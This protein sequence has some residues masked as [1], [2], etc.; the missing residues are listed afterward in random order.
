MNLSE[1]TITTT[2]TLHNPSS[3]TCGRIIWL[4]L[5]CDRF[6]M[7]VGSG[8]SGAHIDA[9]LGPVSRSVGFH[10]EALKETVNDLFWEMWRVWEPA[11]GVKVMAGQD[12]LLAVR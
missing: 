1:N 5:H 7:T 8:D 3:C 6:T 4:S 9:R 2:I 10:P 12:D 11:E